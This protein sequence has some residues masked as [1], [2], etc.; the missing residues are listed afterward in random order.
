MSAPRGG[1]YC[2]WTQVK[3]SGRPAHKSAQRR[4]PGR[5]S[6]ATAAPHLLEVGLAGACDVPLV[7]GDRLL[8]D[9]VRG[10]DEQREDPGE[11]HADQRVANPLLLD[12]HHVLA[13]RL[14]R[15][16]EAVEADPHLGVPGDDHG[17]DQRADVQHEG[18][19]HGV[20]DEVLVVGRRDQPAA[21]EPP[22]EEGDDDLGDQNEAEDHTLHGLA[23]PLDDEL[24][25]VR[26]PA[27]ERVLL[28]GGTDVPPRVGEPHG[29]LELNDDVASP[30]CKD[31]EAEVLIRERQLADL[32]LKLVVQNEV[33]DIDQPSR[34]IP[35]F[36]F[37]LPVELP[38]GHHSRPRQIKLHGDEDEGLRDDA[39][40]A[41]QQG[42]DGLHPDKHVAL[43]LGRGRLHAQGH[44]RPV[45]VLG[46]L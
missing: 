11:G 26:V 33:L 38:R 42:P 3:P 4:W 7:V 22:A 23:T 2:S 6:E 37:V 28:V 8:E 13:F 18:Q 16:L 12:L 20:Q 40:H 46:H 30:D 19:C 34:R 44:G 5:R 39:Q 9:H 17:V 15:Q 32:G 24:F 14:R 45:A 31:N 27:G 29:L 10:R 41:G 36:V 25:L 35:V 1:R 21:S 43:V